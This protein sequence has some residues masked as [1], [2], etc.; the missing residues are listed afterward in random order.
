MSIQRMCELTRSEQ[1]KFLSGLGAEGAR[2]KPRRQLRDATARN[3]AAGQSGD[4]DIG[5]SHRCCSEEPGLLVGE[6]KGGISIACGNDSLLE[7][8]QSQVSW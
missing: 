6:E 4:T 7:V 5:G 3:A 1:G 2:E 8:R